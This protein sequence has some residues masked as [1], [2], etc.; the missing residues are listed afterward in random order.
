MSK[1]RLGELHRL[2]AFVD[3]VA[4]VL[5]GQVGVDAREQHARASHAEGDDSHL[6]A[7]IVNSRA[8]RVALKRR[9]SS[10]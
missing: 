4:D 9:E 8:A 5:V 1:F 6:L 3:E 7:G 2:N 10:Y